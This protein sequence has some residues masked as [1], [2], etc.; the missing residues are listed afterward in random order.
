MSFTNQRQHG[1]PL[2]VNDESST[3]LD[4]IRIE[5]KN[6]GSFDE[7]WLQNLIY[8]NTNLLPVNEIEPAF[9]P[10]I[11]ICRELPTPAGPLDILFCN[12]RGMLTLVECK[13]WRNPEARREVVG[14]ILDYAK[15]FSRWSYEDLNEAISRRNGKGNSLFQIICGINSEIEESEFVDSVSRNLKS[16]KFLLLIV[17]DGIRE[18]VENISNFLQKHASLNFTFALVEEACFL[19]PDEQG[20]G[21]L[22][23]PRTIAKTEIIER[24]V[25]RLDHSSMVV[26]EPDEKTIT[27]K[28]IG[29]RTNLTEQE[30]YQAIK[31]IDP[32]SANQLPQFFNDCSS[33]GLR[34][35][36]R[37]ASMVLN[38]ESENGFLF[39]FGTILKDGKVDHYYFAGKAEE[40]GRLD[41]GEEYLD[42][43][44]SLFSD[45]RV[46][47]LGK[48][49]LWRVKNNGQAIKV[50]EMLKVKDQWLEIISKM[51]EKINHAS[52]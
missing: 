44:S 29:K 41:I 39:N 3:R 33:I 20:G 22:V 14:Q 42:K 19:L 25:V 45:G 40:M 30:F 46:V 32:E 31:E 16:G 52:T 49:W 51:M 48:S 1:F 28:S 4:R 36:S 10:L 17:G 6:Q 2:I 9:S 35:S 50:N 7:N 26:E 34:I 24:S 13:L 8:S 37:P 38:W 11:P 15:E 43:I 23:Q 18:G 21:I 12:D 47:K 5:G 27:H